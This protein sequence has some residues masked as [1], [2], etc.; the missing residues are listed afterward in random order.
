MGGAGSARVSRDASAVAGRGRR[1]RARAT[2]RGAEASARGRSA[3]IGQDGAGALPLGR[4]HPRPGRGALAQLRHPG[5]VGGARGDVRPR[6]R[7]QAPREHRPDASGGADLADRPVRHA[8]RPRERVERSSRPGPVDRSTCRRRAGRRPRRSRRLDRR[9]AE[10][11]SGLL[12]ETSLRRPASG[13][14]GGRH[15]R[16][17]ARHAARIGVGHAQAACRCRRGADDPRRVPPPDGALGPRA[18]RRRRAARA[19]D[20]HRPDGHASRF[21]RP[22]NRRHRAVPALPRTGRLHGARAR[23]RPR[24]LPRPVPG[25]GVLRPPHA[26]RTR[27]RRQYRR[28]LDAARR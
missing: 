18:R 3:R 20:D 17:R 25:P 21:G 8:A 15:R 24:R 4:D 26:G 11:Q 19:S 22:A 13:A 1:R 9:P 6:R 23:T 14:R 16:R 7:G 12:R 27:L 5:P 28:R 2:G 10:A